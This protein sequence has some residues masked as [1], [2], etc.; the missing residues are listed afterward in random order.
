MT[1]AVRSPYD[2]AR[3]PWS[4]E[5]LERQLRAFGET[6]YHNRHPFNQRMHKGE[7]SRAELQLWVANRY[8][9][10]QAIPLKDAAILS[11][12]PEQA[13]RRAWIQRIIDHDGRAESEGGLEAWLRLADA[14]GV[15]RDVLL[16]GTWV[17]PGVQFA[18]DAYVHFCR[19]RPWLEAVAASLTEL[20][21]PTIVSERLAA[22]LTHYA[23][24]EPEGLQ[25]FRNRLSQAPRD[26]EY[27]L[28][29]VLERCVTREW[30][31]RAVAALNFKCD[32][33]W[34][35]LDAVAQGAI[36]EGSP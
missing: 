14:M 17:L 4:P 8:C 15:S 27:A 9:Y 3:A 23:W 1:S 2:D 21:A 31:D 24:I 12:C 20:F 29:L 6:R 30:Q 33:L 7:L 25:Y 35:L 28:G 5:E 32:V 22:I 11:N 13:V 10:Q 19:T 16:S 18:V 36:P 34:S 26:A